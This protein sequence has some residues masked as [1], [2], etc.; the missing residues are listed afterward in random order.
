MQKNRKFMGG[1]DKID[2]KSNFKKL[3]ILNIGGTIFF[4]INFE[5]INGI[6]SKKQ[7]CDDINGDIRRGGARYLAQDN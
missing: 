4:S 2:Q 6:M 3:N 5:P 1:H 7:I